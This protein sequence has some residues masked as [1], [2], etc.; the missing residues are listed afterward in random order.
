MS[1]LWDEELFDQFL[2]NRIEVTKKKNIN[3]VL[4]VQRL[5]KKCVEWHNMGYNVNAIIGHA[6]DVGWRG[7]FLPTGME[8]RQSHLKAGGALAPMVSQVSSKHRMPRGKSQ[9]E[10]HDH[11]NRVRADGNHAAAMEKMKNLG[12]LK[13]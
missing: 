3:T 2:A 8:P 11:A 13:E 4:S 5:R 6:I 1:G 10:R 12:I 9:R 7:L